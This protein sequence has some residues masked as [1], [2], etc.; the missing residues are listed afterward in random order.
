M[1]HYHRERM[2]RLDDGERF[3]DFEV[4]A[5]DVWIGPNEPDPRDLH[6]PPVTRFV[7]P[8]PAT[9]AAE[10]GR[11]QLLLRRVVEWALASHDVVHR[12]RLA[13]RGTYERARGVFRG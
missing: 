7:P 13:V 11:L 2:R 8:P 4:V 5:N 12:A 6:P 10:H 1:R 3:R 9:P